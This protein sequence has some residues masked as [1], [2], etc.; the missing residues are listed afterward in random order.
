[1]TNA[2][3]KSRVFK[4]VSDH[5]TLLESTSQRGTTVATGPRADPIVPPLTPD[6][7]GLFPSP[8]VNTY[9]ACISPWIDLGSPD[10]VIASVSRQVL[11]LEVNY[12]SFCGIRSIIIAGPSLDA[13]KDG[14]NKALAQYSRGVQEALRIGSSLAVLIHMPMYRE[15]SVGDKPATLASLDPHP[16][17]TT[18]P[19]EIDLFSSWDSWHQIRTICNYNMRLFVGMFTG[20][21]C[22]V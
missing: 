13:S 3:F 12:A 1:M 22:T 4:L 18:Q 16:L 15:P 2:N 17:T 11:S 9:T 8:A 20:H 7:T 14:G 6:D 10:P 19:K 5:L 21:M